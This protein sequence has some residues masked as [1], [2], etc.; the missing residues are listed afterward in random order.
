MLSE[1]LALLGDPQVLNRRKGGDPIGGWPHSA[2]GVIAWFAAMLLLG[3][4][5]IGG[6]GPRVRGVMLAGWA[7]GS[8]FMG[9]LL[10]VVAFGTAWPDMKENWLALAFVPLDAMLIWTALR[11]LAGG[12]D[13]RGW[14]R[15]WL[16]FRVWTSGLLIAAT[17]IGITVG[18]LP[19][20][21]LALAGVLFA[22]RCLGKI[23]DPGPPGLF[24]S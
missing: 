1:G 13:A 2:Q 3:A 18:P 14:A 15:G 19:P 24:Q 11:L 10:V 6:R 8:A 4:W 16:R 12:G 21:L 17:V 22:M 5:W 9:T 23:E 7:A 20:R